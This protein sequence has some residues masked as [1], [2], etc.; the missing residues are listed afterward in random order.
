DVAVA[1]GMANSKSDARRLVEQ[2]GVRLND[3]PVRVITAS[4]TEADLDASGTARLTVGKKRH[5]LVRRI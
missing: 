5:G 2:G 1:L 4:V 3:R